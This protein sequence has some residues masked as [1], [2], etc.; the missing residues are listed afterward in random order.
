MH[1][2]DFSHDL[3]GGVVDFDTKIICEVFYYYY[4]IAEFFWG[5]HW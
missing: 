1:E 3:K 4:Y 2:K 5:G